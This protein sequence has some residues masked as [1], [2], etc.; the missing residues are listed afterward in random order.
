MALAS[1]A[2]ADG[3]EPGQPTTVVVGDPLGAAPRDRIDR[4]RLGRARTEL[5]ASAKEL[6]RRE[7]AGGIVLSPVVDATGGIVVPLSSPD[8]VRLDSQGQQTWRTRLGAAPASVPPVITS[9]GSML[10]VSEDG[11]L[12]SISAGGAVRFS[13]DLAMPTKKA[14]AAPL[15]RDD[16]SVVVAGEMGLAIVDAGGTVTARTALQGRPVGGLLPHARGILAATLDGE[17]WHWVPPGSPRRVGDLGGQLPAGVAMVSDR[18]VVGVV[19]RDRVVALD[20]L[21]GAT[22][23]LLSSAAVA[24]P[25]EDT[26]TLTPS[27]RLLAT[28]VVG[29]WVGLDAQGLLVERGALEKLPAM[30]SADAGVPAIFRRGEMRSSPP[31]IVDPRGRI[32]FARNSGKIGVVDPSGK[33]HTATP[34]Q[35]ARPIAILPAG[36]SRFVVACRS[37][38]VALFGDA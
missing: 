13:V 22:T 34:R 6:W 4:R 26:V 33:L 31:L 32:A 14:S 18:T 10:V 16:G 19:E 8:L 2:V 11:I 27:G 24:A 5:P 12:W 7:L 35:C 25:F 15:A 21:N 9:D 3:F 29:E 28:S 30:F 23:L 20:L 1:W 36:P 38:S 17:I 37:G